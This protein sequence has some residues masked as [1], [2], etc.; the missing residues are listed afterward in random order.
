MAPFRKE[1]AIK[2]GLM[3]ATLLPM[4]LL[5]WP[6][7][8]IIDH[9]IGDVVLGQQVRPYPF[10]FQPVVSLLEG[11][12]KLT[13]LIVSIAIEI[14]L[15]IVMGAASSSPG[16]RSRFD[17][18]QLTS[19]QDTATRTENEAN[20][21]FSLV[22]GL[23]GL[24]DYQYTMK[25]T[26]RLNHYYRSRLYE[27]MQALPMTTFDDER[28]GD[29]VYRVMY[30]TPAIT[31]ICYRLILTPI[32]S[33]VNILLTVVVLSS[34]YGAASPVVLLAIGFLPMV[35]IAT[36]PFAS[37]VRKAGARS[38]AAG[39]VTTTTIEESMSS[40]TAVQSLGTSARERKRF[41]TDSSESF[42]A[43]RR[44]A[45]AGML[46]TMAGTVGGSI[47]VAAVFIEIADE[48]IGGT[49]SAGDVGVLLPYFTSIAV[50]AV[51]MGALWIRV[52]E[53]TTG[54][55]RVFWLMD[56]P[57]E[58]DPPGAVALPKVRESVRVENAS[59][60]YDADKPVL[61]DVSFEAKRG[62]LTAFVGP[63][64]TGKT[65]LAYLIPRF[66]SP[67]KGRVLVDGH[68]ISGVTRASLRS[69]VAFVFQETTLFDMSIADNLRM[70]N[71]G[72]SDEEL[73]AAAR[74]A[75]IE[76][77]IESLPEGMQTRLGRSGGKLS[78]GQKQRLSIARALVCPAS[79]MI[80][81]E[82]TSALD[83]D[84]EARIVSALEAAA[85][86]RIV[87]VIAH[88]L[89]TVRNA[90]QILFLQ[91]GQ[92]VERGSHRALMEREG[93]YRRFVELQ[94]LGH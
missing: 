66:L 72:A 51:N 12:D 89:S 38:R 40:I 17:E 18:E 24:V 53:S 63:A 88:R 81:D 13:I 6:A 45:L 80:F 87:I 31:N 9:V 82:P 50:A 70:G 34:V 11:S 55:N 61:K 14:L 23:L 67:T 48:V 56:L 71:P 15:L 77:F 90:G 85:Q 46:A 5:P 57:S 76:D 49:M 28:I 8:L 47:L 83:P 68:D 25:L 73:W 3:I 33:P 43:F 37:V 75:G 39:S 19:G 92:V 69:Q 10:F 22:G 32:G 60:A 94:T 30:D 1:F 42:R 86:E 58:A 7:K 79:I 36:W 16:E 78:V 2:V 65:T 64:G 35:L 20:S 91:E 62:Q 93:P 54:L 26:Q 84:T 41:D 21:G 74:T 4:I 59:F 29:A 52:Q 44:L 27:R